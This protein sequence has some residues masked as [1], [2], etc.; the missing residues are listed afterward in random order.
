MLRVIKNDEGSST[1]E[2]VIIVP[3]TMIVFLVIFQIALWAHAYIVVENAA[4][5]GDQV[6]RSYNTS[7]QQGI[8]ETQS[9]ISSTSG[10][11]ISDVNVNISR[12]VDNV[13]VSVTGKVSSIVPFLSFNVSSVSTSPLQYFRP[14]Q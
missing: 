6:A 11:D 5:L 3:L 14:Q 12:T 2:A 13:N 7:V 10:G 1:A 8:A 9:F 4:S